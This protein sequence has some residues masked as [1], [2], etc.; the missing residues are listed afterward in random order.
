MTTYESISAMKKIMALILVFALAATMCACDG[1]EKLEQV[2]L[3]PLPT[4]EPS[5][6]PETTPEPEESPEPSPEPAELGN[7]VIVSIKNNTEIHNAP[8]NE[9]QRILTFSYDTPQVHIEGNDAAAAVINDHI[10]LL[11]AVLLATGLNDCV[12]AL[13]LLYPN[14]ARTRRH[15]SMP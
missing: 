14:L 6:E 10:A 1:L 5:P 12:H 13:H 8:D 11:D 9:A 4:V 15:A 7:R 3:P 2:E